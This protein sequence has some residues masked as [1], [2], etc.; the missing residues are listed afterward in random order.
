MKVNRF[1]SVGGIFS[2]T[3]ALL[4]ILIIIGGP[5]WYRFFGAGEGMAQ[6]AENGSMYP[7]V[8]TTM[9]A[10]TLGLWGLY[11]FFRCGNY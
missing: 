9:I 6:L 2:I 11:A 5:D 7:T 3:A 1:L 10:M 8:V 4:H